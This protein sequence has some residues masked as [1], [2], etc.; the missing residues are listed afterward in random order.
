M[1]KASGLLDCIVGHLNCNSAP[2]MWLVLFEP[3]Y[4]RFSEWLP[5]CLPREYACGTWP[6]TFMAISKSG[7]T[8]HDFRRTTDQIKCDMSRRVIAGNR[9]KRL[10]SGPLR[11]TI[12][13]YTTD[14]PRLRIISQFTTMSQIFWTC[15]KRY[16]GLRYPPIVRI[17]ADRITEGLTLHGVLSAMA[18]W[19]AIAGLR[20]L[21]IV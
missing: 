4:L 8:L 15:S 18:S 1:R 13:H 14:F 17:A 19:G 3:H 2:S 21:K 10:T 6:G 11:C 9:G 20:K 12:S 16:D 5:Y 7:L